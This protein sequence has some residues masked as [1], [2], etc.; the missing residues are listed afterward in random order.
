MDLIL[1]SLTPEMR[2]ALDASGGLPI[3]IQD[4]ETHKVYLVAERP[5][6]HSL[7]EEYIRAGLQVALEQFARGE[8]DDW[9]IEAVIVEAERR[10]AEQVN[11]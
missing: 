6:L 5:P 2:Q 9:D 11:G 8:H 1:Q 7:D 3:Q 4:P 10:H